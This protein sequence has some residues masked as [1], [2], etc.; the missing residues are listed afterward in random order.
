MLPTTSRLPA[1]V[2]A[3]AR[4]GPAS[5]CVAAG[6]SSITAGTFETR[7]ESTHAWPRRAS[8]DGRGR[9]RR[10][11]A[12]RAPRASAPD[13]RERVVHD[14]EADEQHQQLPVDEGQHLARGHAAAAEQHARRRRGPRPRGATARAGTPARPPRAPGPLSCVCQRVER[15][16]RDLAAAAEPS[17]RRSRELDARSRQTATSPSAAGTPPIEQVA[18]ER[19]AAAS[20]RSACSAGCR[21]GWPPSRRSR[22]RR[23]RAGT[24]IGS[25]RRRAQASTTI[26]AMARQ[27]M[28]LAS[29][30]ER[31]PAASTSSASRRCGERRRGRRDGASGACRS[32]RAGTG[33]RPPSAR[34]A[35]PWSARRSRRPAPP[36]A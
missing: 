30:A 2:L 31:P 4:I 17:R 9:R 7:F 15:R 36:P 8:R 14:E 28:S 13:G 23:A 11:P 1:S 18:A 24:G 32:R 20:G 27:T 12:R 21:S 19:Q 34:R 26:G 3:R 22:R 16:R 6:S 25:R 29:R 5:G 33:P 10:A 35:A